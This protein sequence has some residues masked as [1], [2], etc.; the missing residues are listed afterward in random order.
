L[1]AAV[2]A[3]TVLLLVGCSAG[4]PTRPPAGAQ[5]SAGE[6]PPA[7]AQSAAGERAPAGGASERAVPS[8]MSEPPPDSA[9]TDYGEAVAAMQVGDWTEAELRLEQLMLE[10]PSLPGPYVNAAI[11]YM[12]DGRDDPARAA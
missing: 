6:R 3:L 1:S 8:S 12:R 10:Y 11:L 2:S 9:V 4:T 5:S 7:G